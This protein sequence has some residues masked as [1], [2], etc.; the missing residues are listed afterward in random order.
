MTAN[1]NNREPIVRSTCRFGAEPEFGVAEVNAPAAS[2]AVR[3]EQVRA[4]A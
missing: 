4:S 3:F 2:L 1:C